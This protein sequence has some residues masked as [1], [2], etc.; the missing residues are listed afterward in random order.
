[1]K[2]CIH[3][4]QQSQILSEIQPNITNLLCL[5][6]LLLESDIELAVDHLTRPLLTEED[7]R[8][9]SAHVEHA[10]ICLCPPLSSFLIP[11]LLPLL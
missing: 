6:G 11:V 7:D 9:W 5:S 4:G 8:V 10:F 2:S 1:M 3:S